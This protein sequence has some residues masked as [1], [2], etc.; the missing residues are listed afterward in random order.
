MLFDGRP[1]P[2]LGA[3]RQAVAVLPRTAAQALPATGVG[4][5]GVEPVMLHRVPVQAEVRDRVGTPRRR[6]MPDSLRGLRQRALADPQKRFG[7][8]CCG[9][10]RHRCCCSSGTEGGALGCQRG[11]LRSL[12]HPPA[13]ERRFH[14]RSEHEGEDACRKEEADEPNPR[15]LHCTSMLIC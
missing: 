11:V 2:L 7:E 12:E 13:P 6:A 4:I 1:P 5:V 3:I 15:E 9:S 8:R 10:P 14:E